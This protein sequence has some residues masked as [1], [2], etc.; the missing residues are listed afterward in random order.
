MKRLLLIILLIS[1][2]AHADGLTG[3]LFYTPAQRLQLEAGRNRPTPPSA[4][5]PVPTPDTLYNG[6]VQRSDGSVTQWI[7]G[8]PHVAGRPG[9]FKLPATPALK[10]GQEYDSASGRILEPYQRATPVLSVPE[11]AAP[12]TRKPPHNSLLDGDD[13]PDDSRNDAR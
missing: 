1:P 13:V 8:E 10:P 3:R 2:L 6:Y 5:R 12:V 4:D 11:P 9:K 7:N